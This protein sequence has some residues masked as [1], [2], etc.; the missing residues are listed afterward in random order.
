MSLGGACYVVIPEPLTVWRWVFI[1]N[2]RGAVS[3]LEG[4]LAAQIAKDEPGVIGHVIAASGNH[5]AIHVDMYRNAMIPATAMAAAATAVAQN[6]RQPSR[7]Q[8][9][10]S[11]H[12]VGQTLGAGA[13]QFNGFQCVLDVA[14][15]EEFLQVFHASRQLGFCLGLVGQDIVQLGL[16][17]SECYN[18]H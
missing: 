1:C 9:L 13:D 8:G 15:Q 10:M 12:D 7:L 6:N 2:E 4:K 18:D 5:A 16:Q 17:F 11:I 3:A 14:A